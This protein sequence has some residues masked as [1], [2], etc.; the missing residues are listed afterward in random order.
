[1]M[2]IRRPLSGVSRA[3]ML[4]AVL[5][6]A[7]PLAAQGADL[8]PDATAGSGVERYL[9]VLQVA[10]RAPLYP[11]TVRGFSPREVDRLVPADSG[12]PWAARFPAPAAHRGPVSLRWI[13]PRVGATFNSAFPQGGNDGAVWA[14][15][16]VTGVASA[17]FALRAGVLSLRVEPVAFW[18]QNRAFALMDNGRTGALAYAD[19]DFPTG[20]DNPQRFGSGSYARVD[21]GQ[22]TLRVDV[23][24]FA[25]GLSTANE[26]WGPAEDLPVVL[27]TNAPGFPHLFVGTSSPWNVG[28]GRAHVRV[29]W[30]RLEQSDYSSVTGGAARRFTTGWA[31]SFSPRG[32]PG[33]EVGASRFFHTTW[34]AGGPGLDDF[35]EP[36]QAFFKS[37]VDSTGVGPDGRTSFDNQIASAFARLVLPSSGVELWGEFG[38]NDHS[39]DLQDFFLEP[40]HDAATSVG[41]RKVWGTG[42]RLF[43]LRA[44]WVGARPSNLGLVRHQSSF[45]THDSQRQGHTERGQLLGSP[46]VYGGGGSVVALERYTPGGRW[47]VDW[48]RTRVRGAQEPAADGSVPPT[49][50]VHSLGGEALLFHRGVDVLGRLRGSWEL[51]RYL[52]RDAFNLSAGLSARIA[53]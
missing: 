42:R 39:W 17:G 13:A 52:E 6:W 3:G 37:R 30:G 20:I 16:G 35:L 23:R 5:A 21:P 24:G 1:M 49:D 12:H 22:S 2:P 44:E 15:R 4:A 41:A 53:L 28:I 26:A 36:F 45:Y 25:A 34:P 51:D 43:S 9:R 50:V 46:A 29:Q 18:A 10:G 8:R 27:G 38:R 40:D 7:A 33:L 32:L 31:L 47:S 14:G 11:W 48:T 19:A